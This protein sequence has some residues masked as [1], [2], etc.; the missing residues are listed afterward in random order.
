MAI[1]CTNVAAQA[2]LTMRVEAEKATGQ[3]MVSDNPD[4]GFIVADSSGN[5]L[6]PN[7]LSSNIPF[8]LDDNAAARVGI[9]AWPVSVTG[10]KPTEGPFTA[11]G[12][13]RVD[14]D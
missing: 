8:Q 11:R 3:M 13:L 7:N 2:Y 5:P 12:Y 6:T 14:Y 10:N 4:L 9:R 1:K